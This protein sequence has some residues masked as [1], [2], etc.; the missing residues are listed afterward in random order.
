MDSSHVAELKVTESP[1]LY[2][3]EIAIACVYENAI[4]SLRRADITEFR[5]TEM[6][7][8]ILAAGKRNLQRTLQHIDKCTSSFHKNT[9]FHVSC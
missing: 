7:P 6:L 3:Y 4:H 8:P 9:P 5:A 1:Q 2:V